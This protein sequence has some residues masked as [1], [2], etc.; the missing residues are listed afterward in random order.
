[1]ALA[2]RRSGVITHD[3][4][5][6]PTFGGGGV[7]CVEIWKEVYDLYRVGQCSNVYAEAALG[8]RGA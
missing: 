5:M 3:Q 7:C 2:V 1:M 8:I 6:V 4:V